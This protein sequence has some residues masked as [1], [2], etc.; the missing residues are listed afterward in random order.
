ME[1]SRPRGCA[2]ALCGPHGD[3]GARPAR[4]DVN[5]AAASAWPWLQCLGRR[6][7]HAVRAASAARAVAAAGA[8]PAPRTD[9]GGPCRRPARA[10]T[11]DIWSYNTSTSIHGVLFDVLQSGRGHK[12]FL[13]SSLFV[14]SLGCAPPPPP[15]GPMKR[16]RSSGGFPGSRRRVG[17]PD[18]RAGGKGSKA[19]ASSSWCGSC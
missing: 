10:E 19:R 9:A 11:G 1:T 5:Y 17:S 14:A 2:A 18:G 7:S 4:S 16:R 15:S 6:G 8:R 3:N 12:T 13:R